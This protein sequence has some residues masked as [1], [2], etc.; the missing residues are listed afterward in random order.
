MRK[1]KILVT[2]VATLFCVGETAAQIDADTKKVISS[3]KKSNQYI[4]AEATAA[5]ADEAKAL[6]EEMLHEEINSYV[7]TKNKMRGSNI[8]INNR[9]SLWTAVELPR[10]NMFRSFLYVKKSDIQAVKNV[11]VI[12]NK[13]QDV[14]EVKPATVR[15]LYPEVVESVAKCTKYADMAELVKRLKEEGKIV[16]YGRYS[17]LSNPEIYYLAIYNK[18]GDVVAVLT[19]GENRV[20][21]KTGN[22]D[23][24]TNY[25]G[26]GAIG[27]KVNN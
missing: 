10:G 21:V 7:A 22:A 20:N 26:C 1:F 6:A 18:D 25:S 16:H 3:I 8:V 4:Y 27:F 12:E 15:Q 14:E 19:P 17:S 24:L 2:I 11:E 13:S 5:T 9:N 23:R